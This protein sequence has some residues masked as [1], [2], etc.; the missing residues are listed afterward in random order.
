[1]QLPACL[2]KQSGFTLIELLMGAFLFAI[3]APGFM[4]VFSKGLDVFFFERGELWVQK[5]ISRV[6]DRITDQL[7][8]AASLDSIAATDIIFDNSG[9]R[10][11]WDSN[12][13]AIYDINNNP[14]NSD[15]IKVTA[16]SF[17]YDPSTQLVQI[18]MEFQRVNQPVLEL[19][20]QVSLRNLL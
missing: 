4:L 14:V 19:K 9:K 8:E 13:Q 12:S 1:M 6:M 11:Y 7:R 20:S 16:L 18:I 5:D 10:Y 2:K 17:A 3:L 15:E